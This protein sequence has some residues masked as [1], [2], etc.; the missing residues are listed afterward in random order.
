M[1][2]RL[3]NFS[4]QRLDTTQVQLNWTTSAE[5]N[6]DYFAI[7][8]SA[9]PAAGFETIGSVK[10]KG[11]S[12][13]N[14]NYQFVDPNTSTVYTYYRLKQVDLDGSF[15]YSQIIAVKGAVSVLAVTVFPNPGEA[16]QINFRISGVGME[17]NVSVALYDQQG[18]LLHREPNARLDADQGFNIPAAL[19]L[20][21]GTYIVR[22]GAK[23]Q[24][25]AKSFIVRP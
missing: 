10:G 19:T 17:E 2:V 4:G 23:N 24:Q 21:P 6:N 8:R 7:Q 13:Q 12:A 15:S 22:V 1:P 18:R 16:R 9:N 25:A 3:I 20:A 11:T 5:I 14:V